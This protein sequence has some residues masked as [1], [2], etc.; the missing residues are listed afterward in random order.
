MP[1]GT[2]AIEA[3]NPAT[4][5]AFPPVPSASPEDAARAV[6]AAREASREW[7]A[8]PIRERAAALKRLSKR[9]LERGD[10]VARAIT[11]SCGKPIVESFSSE[12]F[13]VAYL[14]DHYSRSA[15]RWLKPERVS[16]GIFEW[17]GRRSRVEHRPWGAVAIIA[18]WNYPF[19]IPMGEIAAALVAGN[20][21]VFK[22]SEITPLVGEAIRELVTPEVPA[23]LFH[24]LQG[25]GD[26]GAA[27]TAV[28][29][30][31]I[32][33]TGSVP[34][35]RRIGASAG[36]AL[37]PSVL[38][39]GGKDPMVVF[40]DADLD[41]AAEGAVWGAFTN[42][43]Q[44]CASVERLYVERAVYDELL[45]RIVARTRKLRQ[46]DP[47]STDT[48]VGSMTCG[49]QL[50]KVEHQVDEALRLG[51]TAHT[52][53][54]RLDRPGFWF[55][56]TVMTDVP[57][58]AALMRE[59]TFGPVLPITPFD[60]EEDAVGLANDS[61]YGL[62]ASVWTRDRKRAR[63]VAGQLRAG[64][65]MINEASYT[66]GMPQTP[67]GGVGDSGIGRTHGRHGVMEM[68]QPVHMHE[69][70][71]SGR[72]SLWWYPYS[73]RSIDLL[74]RMAEGVTGGPLKLLR[75][76]FSVRPSDLKPRR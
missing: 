32:V 38:E 49:M 53:G 22:P 76:V 30:D 62:T 74:R 29:P 9:L 54:R 61:P 48:D 51:A 4:G 66:H 43:G 70:R 26:I 52:G 31:K 56:P 1:V 28:R 17:F 2:R 21:V 11:R 72:R 10:E 12:V 73:Q 60:S 63:R 44:V 39:L 5:E 37:I 64:T 46:G 36:Q 69:N 42:S 27:L 33:F 16:L 68:V 67:W 24:V 59:E 18:P 25:A 6:A 75:W 7:A 14:L 41:V 58:D 71:W 13:P 3:I 23:G 47:T 50:A 45:R 19:S 40:A 8:R 65:V 57:A 34:T 55:P 35:G 20:G 15:P